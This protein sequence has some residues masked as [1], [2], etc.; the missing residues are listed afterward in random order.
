M[1]FVF[2]LDGTI[3]FKGSPMSKKIVEALN[4]L[5]EQEH[6]VIFASARPI[7]DMLPIVDPIFHKNLLIGGNG[8]LTSKNKSVIYS[9]YS[10]NDQLD[11]IKRIMEENDATYL[12]DGLWDYT[13]TGLPNHPILQ[14]L[15]LDNS[16]K[17]V[18]LT[19]HD[20]IVKILILSA[21]N[22]DSLQSSLAAIDV[23]SH[24]HSQKNILD[25]SP[26]GIHKLAALTEIGIAKEGYVAFGNDSNDID[27]FKGAKYSVMV[28]NHDEL[29]Q[30]ADI[31]IP[32]NE[33][34]EENIIETINSLSTQY[35][36]FLA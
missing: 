13:Y 14:N 8:S 2:D 31:N 6:T 28:G 32:I 33:S 21:K 26:P 23:V 11:Y 17:N 22:L 30:Y 10:S 35:E 18:D 19:T 4:K 3:C 34:L 27:M 25:I 24:Y 29:S 5:Q 7:R 20:A 16:A 15:D 12:I 9:K 36:T 1:N